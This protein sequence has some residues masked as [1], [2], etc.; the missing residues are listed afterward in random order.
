MSMRPSATESKMPVGEGGASQKS[1][2]MSLVAWVAR[3]AVQVFTW[4]SRAREGVGGWV[5]L[6]MNE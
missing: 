5:T 3:L 1:S 2:A 4:V 6:G